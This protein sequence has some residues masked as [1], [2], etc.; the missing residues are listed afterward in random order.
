VEKLG[1]AAKSVDMSKVYFTGKAKNR[2]DAVH[3]FAGQ[4]GG[5]CGQG[6]NGSFYVVGV[7]VR[8]KVRWLTMPETVSADGLP[9]IT[10]PGTFEI[11]EDT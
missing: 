4:F 10:V 9:T 8:L 7:N 5:T 3:Q 2:A 6:S 1:R 11:V